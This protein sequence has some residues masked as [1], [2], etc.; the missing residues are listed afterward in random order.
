MRYFLI[1]VLLGFGACIVGPVGPEGAQGIQGT[2]GPEGPEGP[3]PAAVIVPSEIESFSGITDDN[4]VDSFDLASAENVAIIQIW[5]HVDAD[6]AWYSVS[7]PIRIDDGIVRFQCA[8][9]G[10]WKALVLH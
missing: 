7:E 6:T 1:A 2:Q 10:R 4:G 3:A 5:C 9:P 8:E